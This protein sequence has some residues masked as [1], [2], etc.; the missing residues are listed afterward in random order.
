M[1]SSMFT[2]QPSTL[3][4]SRPN[5]TGFFFNK[6][7]LPFDDSTIWSLHTLY[8]YTEWLI[9]FETSTITVAG[10]VAVSLS[11]AC[12]AAASSTT[13]HGRSTPAAAGDHLLH[14]T[15]IWILVSSTMAYLVSVTKDV[16]SIAAKQVNVLLA[17]KIPNF[18]ALSPGIKL[19]NIPIYK[20]VTLL[21]LIWNV[22]CWS[23]WMFEP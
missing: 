1:L 7:L 4:D 18:T 9:K 21:K 23:T 2:P 3:W 13:W 11:F 6:W 17:I 20:N 12:S 14:G 16:R 8:I 5:I 22:Q 10:P 15:W 19:N